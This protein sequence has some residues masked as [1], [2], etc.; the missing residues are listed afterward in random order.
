[1]L[2]ASAADSTR[3]YVSNCDAGGVS[4]IRTT[5]DTYVL[6]LTAPQGIFTPPLVHIVA[7]S[8]DSVA[9]TVTYT[10]DTGD[11]LLKLKQT[12]V[13]SGIADG[14]VAGIDHDNGTFVI[15]ALGTNTFT[16]SNPFGVS[17]NPSDPPLN[18]FGVPQP[19]PRPPAQSPLFLVAGP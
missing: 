6:N 5:D 16:V 2:T 13:V 12:I 19:Q 18:G 17:S 15:T 1:M 11:A 10:Y 3:V 7:A 14:N 4:S 9:Q 8:F